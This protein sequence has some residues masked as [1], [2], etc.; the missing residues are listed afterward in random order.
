MAKT[1]AK[2]PPKA[3]KIASGWRGFKGR[4]AYAIQTRQDET[5]ELT[6]NDVADSAGIDSGQ[7]AKIL[8]GERALGVTANTVLL[9]AEALDVS[10]LWLMTGVEPSGLARKAQ[11]TRNDTAPP[12]SSLVPSVQPE[13]PSQPTP[14]SASGR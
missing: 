4:L 7:L 11:V 2:A 9:L 5:P 1:K 6:Q 8:S 3:K 13:P 12:P 10:A 14:R